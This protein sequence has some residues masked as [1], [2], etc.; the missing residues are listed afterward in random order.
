[1]LQS[2]PEIHDTGR[3]QLFDPP[4][5]WP[6]TVAPKANLWLRGYYLN[7]ILVPVLPHQQFSSEQFEV[8]AMDQNIFTTSQKQ[9]THL[10]QKFK[11]ILTNKQRQTLNERIL[12]LC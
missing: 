2:Q 6:F 12:A 11:Q 5:D 4:F 7:Q 9:Q 1:M 10:H 8:L 3:T